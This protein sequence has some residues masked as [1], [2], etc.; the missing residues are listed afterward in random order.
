MCF[1]LFKS[2][3]TTEGNRPTYQ[4]FYLKVNI[5]YIFDII[6]KDA[7][8]KNFAS[9]V[10]YPDYFDISFMDGNYQISISLTED[11][12][13]HT[14]MDISVKN[15][16]EKGGAKKMLKAKLYYYYDLLKDYLN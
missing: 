1:S 7:K 5:Q 6:A 11:D 14:F 12:K 15:I 3:A 9:F 13:T 16:K 4:N 2:Y 8:E 10:A